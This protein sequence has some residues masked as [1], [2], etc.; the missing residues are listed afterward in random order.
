MDNFPHMGVKIG[1][2]GSWWSALRPI[3]P[4]HGRNWPVGGECGNSHARCRR[5][6]TLVT[7]T[8]SDVATVSGL[9]RIHRTTGAQAV[10]TVQQGRARGAQNDALVGVPPTVAVLTGRVPDVA[11]RHQFVARDLSQTVAMPLATI[12]ASSQ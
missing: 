10:A 5:V 4:L 3:A 7:C 6:A 12:S 2:N 1:K 11:N 8:A 9:D